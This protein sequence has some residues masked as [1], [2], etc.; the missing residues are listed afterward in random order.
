M[1]TIKAWYYKQLKVEMKEFFTFYLQALE[2]K[3]VAPNHDV[4]FT[5]LPENR[6]AYE[7]GEANSI[8]D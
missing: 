2:A 5:P 8:E 1:S 6:Q 7:I 4:I 3:N